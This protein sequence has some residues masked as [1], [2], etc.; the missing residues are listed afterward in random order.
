MIPPTATGLD[1]DWHHALYV[2]PCT[3]CGA[4]EE[5]VPVR[6]SPKSF[7]AEPR[8]TISVQ[9]KRSNRDSRSFLDDIKAALSSDFSAGV[10]VGARR[11][12]A[13]R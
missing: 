7:P 11:H 5:T 12:S 13:S 6:Q 10:H 2:S 8:S 9:S 1:R 3:A 4:G